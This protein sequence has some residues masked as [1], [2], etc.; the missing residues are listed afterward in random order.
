MKCKQKFI[1]LLAA[2]T[3][4]VVAVSFSKTEIN[5]AVPHLESQK[6]SFSELTG[7]TSAPLS[8][9]MFGVAESSRTDSSELLA[10]LFQLMFILFIISPPIIALML[11][12]IWKELKERN[13]LK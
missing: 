12:L 1:R 6:S 11:F 7:E 8:Q 10:R 2:I 13:K 9:A 5:N 3:F 4:A